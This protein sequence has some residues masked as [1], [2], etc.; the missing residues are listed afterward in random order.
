MASKFLIASWGSRMHWVKRGSYCQVAY[1]PSPAGRERN[2]STMP[3]MTTPPLSIVRWLRRWC[4]RRSSFILGQQSSGFVGKSVCTVI[5]RTLLLARAALIAVLA[6]RL[7]A[8]SLTEVHAFEQ[9]KD[10]S[11]SLRRVELAGIGAGGIEIDAGFSMR[12]HPPRPPLL[13]YTPHPPS[14]P[15]LS[16]VFALLE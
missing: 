11:A 5:S 12:R 1:S 6:V 2:C 3:T 8:C 7:G 10:A 9:G 4:S 13:P 15:A 14:R 16:R